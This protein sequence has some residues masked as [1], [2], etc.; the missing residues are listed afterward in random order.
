MKKRDVMGNVGQNEQQHI[1]L[2][3]YYFQELACFAMMMG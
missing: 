2:A 3:L 1:T